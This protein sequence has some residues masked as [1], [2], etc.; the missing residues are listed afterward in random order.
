MINCILFATIQKTLEYQFVMHAHDADLMKPEKFAGDNFKRWQSK[1]RHYLL[2]KGLWWIIPQVRP[3]THHQAMDFELANDTVVDVMLSLL[4]NQL[5][6]VYHGY[7]SAI[8]LWEAWDRKY[9]VSDAGRWIYVV[10]QYHD[11]RM[12]DGVSVVKQAHDL[13]SIVS[14]LAQFDVQV[15]AKFLADSLS[16]YDRSPLFSDL[17]L[18][19]AQFGLELINVGSHNYDN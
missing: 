2:S 13:T 5:Y 19:L 14:E 6:D 17:L 8:E 16:L 10:E 15:N 18:G 11:F 7:T 9:A 4:E 3:L 12:V 1:V